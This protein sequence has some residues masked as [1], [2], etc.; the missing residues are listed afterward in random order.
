ML[1]LQDGLEPKL[2][3]NRNHDNLPSFLNASTI[4]SVVEVP[5]IAGTAIAIKLKLNELKL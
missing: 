4:D 5:L 2:L 3:H 1:S